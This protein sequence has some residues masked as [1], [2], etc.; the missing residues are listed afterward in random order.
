[1]N[2]DA[3]KIPYDI[4]LDA[5]SYANERLKASEEELDHAAKT[6]REAAKK[7]IQEAKQNLMFARVAGYLLIELF[8]RREILTNGPYQSLAKQLTSPPRDG[9]TTHDIVIQVG[10]WHFD[11]LLRMC[12]FVSPLIC[13][14]SQFPCRLYGHQIV[15]NSFL[16][17]LASLL[18]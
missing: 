12:T 13:S 7:A 4:V 18:R 10:K 17:P 11:H 6:G 16:T 9:G 5:E 8:T 2:K 14:G 15:P 3:S 1:M